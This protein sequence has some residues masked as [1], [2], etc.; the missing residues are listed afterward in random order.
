M[1]ILHVVQ[2]Y[3]PAVGGTEIQVQRI[4][5]E[6]ARQFGDLVTVFTSDCF[7]AGGFVN[8]RARRFPVGK[9]EI[10]GVQVHR[11]RAFN[12][13]GPVLKPLQWLAFR[14]G[15][16]F[17]EYLRVWY[18]GPHLPGLRAAIQSWRGDV[19][20]A[21]SLPLLH[22]FTALDAAVQSGKPVVIAGSQHP[23]DRWGYDRPMIDR[24]IRRA[25]AYIAMT[26]F[27]ADYVIRRGA[28]PERVSVIGNGVD[29][30]AFEACAQAEGKA[31]LGLPVDA[32]L[33]GFIGQLG[34]LKGVDI[35][36][37]AMPAVWEAFPEAR[38]L[39]AGASTSFR[40]KLEALVNSL[41]AGQRNRVIFKPDF[42]EAEKGMLIAALD[43]LAY[44]SGFES[45]GIAYLEAWAAGKPVI[46]CRRGAVPWVVE[47]DV[48]GL[49][50]GYQDQGALAKAVISLLANPA[51]A[52]RLGEKGRQKVLEKYTW[53]VIAR[54]F[55]EVYAR[56]A[57]E[58]P[59]RPGQSS[60]SQNQVQ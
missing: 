54:R 37:E 23:E 9:E 45:F 32:P 27:E 33:V 55:R 34:R 31:R 39:I 4:S 18:S 1:N 46:G 50:V 36:I 60:R 40:P 24:A 44:P 30:A 6:L 8:P 38:L 2:G 53:P 3:S 52:R 15:L 51:L 10:N 22:I 25:N 11:F 20:A 47:A 41:T 12:L 29:P 56:A 14:L 5:E 17:N 58:G 7:N 48:D 57:A 21:A 49:L 13:A 16:P 19:V 43:V 42:P 59:L 26:G 28:D 35:L